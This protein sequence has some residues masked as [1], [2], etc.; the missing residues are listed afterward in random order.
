ML[1]SC[2]VMSAFAQGMVMPMYG[3]MILL[4]MQEDKLEQCLHLQRNVEDVMEV[5]NVKTVE[6]V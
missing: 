3:G 4:L 5:E 2:E 1:S 6:E